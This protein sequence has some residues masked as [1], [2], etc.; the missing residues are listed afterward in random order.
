MRLRERDTEGDRPTDR[1]KEREREREREREG[2]RERETRRGRSVTGEQGG[3][4][5]ELALCQER[6]CLGL[7]RLAYALKRTRAM[8][9]EHIRW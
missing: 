4:R 1:E 8:V 9:R 2:G 5:V 6:A 7:V 3:G